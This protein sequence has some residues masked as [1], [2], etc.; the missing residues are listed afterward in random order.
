MDRLL[1]RQRVQ[2]NTVLDDAEFLAFY[3]QLR[4]D[5]TAILSFREVYNL[6]RYGRMALSV[7]GDFAEVGVFRGG[8]AR[9]LKEVKNGRLLHLF[10]TFSGMPETDPTRDT[11]HKAGDFADASLEAVQRY[12]G[13]AGIRYYAGFFPDTTI[14]HERSLDRFAFVHLDVDIYQ[15]TLDALRFF[16]PRVSRGGML[17]THDYSAQSCPGVAAAYDEFFADKAE[18]VLPV[19]DSQA[20]VIKQ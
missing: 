10:D 2:N 18:R 7:P 19:W 3:Q 15:S 9:V 1:H 13:T 11:T 6:W 8:G 16:Y 4:E 14:G 20:V 17:V 5:R 12:L